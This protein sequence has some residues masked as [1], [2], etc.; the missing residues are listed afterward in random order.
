MPGDYPIVRIAD[1]RKFILAQIPPRWLPPK[2]LSQPAYVRTGII[3]D[4]GV[5]VLTGPGYAYYQ[6]DMRTSLNIINC[7]D[8][9][10][11]TKS[12]GSEFSGT[13]KWIITGM[14]EKAR[15]EVY[16]ANPAPMT[17]I[18]IRSL[19]Q[20]TFGCCPKGVIEVET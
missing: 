9:T 5:T 18:D 7:Y 8:V 11:L 12:Y 15:K 3:I 19:T 16:E 1:Y 2:I 10:I 6:Y 13:E 4:T 17:F 20:M 14:Y